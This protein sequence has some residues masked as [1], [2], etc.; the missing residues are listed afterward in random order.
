VQFFFS[1]LC[2]SQSSDAPAGNGSDFVTFS[3]YDEAWMS[4]ALSLAH[5]AEKA[6]DVPVGCVIVNSDGLVAEGWNAREV[7]RDPLA[8]AEIIAIQHA[9]QKLQR[10]RLSD[11]TLYVTLEPCFMCAGAIVLARIPRVVFATC[12]PKA[13]AGGSLANVLQDARLN[14]RCIVHSGLK[15]P[16]AANLLKGFFAEKRRRKGQ[17]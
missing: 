5:Q 10:W 4:H 14:H 15:R 3:E 2:L 7:Q 11:C 6:G 16:E 9:A 12:D 1:S 17:I 13:G 8:H